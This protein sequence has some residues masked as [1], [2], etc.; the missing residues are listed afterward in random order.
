MP[1]EPKPQVW[2]LLT[3]TRSTLGIQLASLFNNWL[4]E[5]QRLPLLS[6][7][8]RTIDDEYVL[9]LP[10]FAKLFQRNFQCDTQ[11]HLLLYGLQLQEFR[12][13][14]FLRHCGS[15]W[16]YLLWCTLPADSKFFNLQVWTEQQSGKGHLSLEFQHTHHSSNNDCSTIIKFWEP[17][18]LPLSIVHPF[19]AW[20]SSEQ[21]R[22]IIR[23]SCSSGKMSHNNG[24]SGP[25][26]H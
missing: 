16:R 14:T 26:H 19:A 23:L 25:L 1:E 17:F 3:R 8:N 24:P 18:V 7:F 21:L 22:L 13:L 4:F 20:G 10:T 9:L 12:Q 11:M 6:E 2:K 15:R 5:L